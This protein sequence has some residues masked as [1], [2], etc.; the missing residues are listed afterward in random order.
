MVSVIPSEPKPQNEPAPDL[1][2]RVFDSINLLQRIAVIQLQP[3]NAQRLLRLEYLAAL[4]ASFSDETG[5]P[6]VSP[7]R[8]RQTIEGGMGISHLE[9]RVT[10][11]LVESM[12]FFGGAYL[13]MPGLTEHLRPGLDLLLMAAD[14][15]SVV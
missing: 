5:K 9:D 7:H 2:L 6:F 11:P 14:R 10:W 4:I 12:A 15:K 8:L 1:G 3:E 13:V